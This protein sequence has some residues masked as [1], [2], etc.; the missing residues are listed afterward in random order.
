MKTRIIV[1]AALMTCAFAGTT[2]AAIRTTN[3]G[4]L[5]DGDFGIVTNVFFLPQTFQDTFN[6]TLS[7]TSTVSG[8]FSPFRLVDAAWNLSS[9][10]GAIAG[11][12]MSFGTYTFSD[13][14]PGSYSLSI[15]GGARALSGYVATYRVAVAAVP[16][17][18]TWLMLVIGLGLAAYQLHRKQKS[19]GLQALRD[20]SPSPA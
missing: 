17:P 18:E 11:G 5:S 16:E 2:N 12:A 7:S 13:L 15:F 10:S 14:A 9:S 20:E 1:L 6:F 4:A 8:L 3:L 19:L